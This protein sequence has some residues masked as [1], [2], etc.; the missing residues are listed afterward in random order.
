MVYSP[1]GYFFDEK[2]GGDLTRPMYLMYEA[3]D[4]S[5][6][7]LAP[8]PGTVM[9]KR[10]NC[11]NPKRPPNMSEKDFDTLC[12]FIEKTY[13]KCAQMHNIKCQ[14]KLEMVNGKSTAPPELIPTTSRP[15]TEE[16]SRNTTPQ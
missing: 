5:F 13:D 9:F 8:E 10:L 4:A 2:V 7:S 14:P 12:K 6:A 15:S 16:L 3:L 11:N 1:S